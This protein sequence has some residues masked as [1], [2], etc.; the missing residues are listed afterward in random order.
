MGVII[1]R[2]GGSATTSGSVTTIGLAEDGTYTDGLFTDFVPG[3]PIGTAVD[4]FNEIL[5]SLVPPPAP[6][7]SSMSTADTGVA[8]RLSFGTSNVIFGYTNHPTLDINGLLSLSSTERVIFNAS[9]TMNGAL[10]DNVVADANGAYPALAFGGASSGSLLLEVNGTTIH[11]IGL[12]SFISGTDLNASGSGFTGVSSATPVHFLNGSPFGLFQFRTGSWVVASGSQRHGYNNARVRLEFPS[13]TFLNT[14]TFTWVVD[15]NTSASLYTNEGLSALSMSG[16]AYLSGIQYH[17]SGNC[18]Y[19][20]TASNVHRNTYSN[21]AT[22]VSHPT[23]TRCSIPSQPLV[24]ITTHSASFI[25]NSGT[26]TVDTDA[27]ILGQSLTVDTQVDRTVQADLTSAGDTKFQILLDPFI[28]AGNSSNSLEP[29]DDELFRMHTGLSLTDTSYGSGGPQASI[30]DWDSTQGLTGSNANHNT[31][32]LVYN[33]GIRYPTQG[34]NA[35]DFSIVADGPPG[36]PNYSAASG[37]RTF[38]RYFYSSAVVQNFNFVMTVSGTTFVTANNVGSLA[39]NQVAAEILAPNTTQTG[40]SMIEFKDMVRAFTTINAKGAFAA[41]FGS[42]IPTN[43]GVTL[44]TRS[45]ATSGKVVVM[46]FTAASTWVGSI[47]HISA[48]FLV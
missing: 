17:L 45:T 28:L 24:A 31:G 1:A 27:R 23:T 35:G 7:L 33:G 39:G 22:A 32:L 13:G 29:F 20:V 43:W 6:D 16:S 19:S 21:S 46:R 25:I 47:T 3:T 11:S 5:K 9:N 34:I 26:V 15:D 38:I 18:R 14:Q 30:Y 41:S 48:T 36:N 8:G 40:G 4:R 12:D 44:G 10:A 42:T 37:E 2:P